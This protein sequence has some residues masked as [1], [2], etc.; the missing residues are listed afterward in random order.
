MPDKDRNLPLVSVLMTSYNGEK[1]IA[2]AIESVLASTYKDFELIIVDDCSMDRTLEIAE[3]YAKKDLRISVYANEK[4]LGDYPNRNRVAGLAKGKYLKYIDNDDMIYPYGLEVVVNMMEQFPDAGYG[5]MSFIQDDSRIYPYQ[6][7]AREAYKK[8]YFE[9]ALLHKAAS[10]SIIRTD[11]FRAVGGFT[12]KRMFGD[13][14]MWHILSRKYP[15][16]LL[17]DGVVWWRKHAEQEMQHYRYN[18]SIQFDYLL[19]ANQL[20]LHPESPLNSSERERAVH[21]IQKRQARYILRYFARGSFSLAINLLEKSNFS[22]LGLLIN[23]F[24]KA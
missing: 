19:V 21:F 20:L 10:S 11:I 1:Y 15:V 3:S 4:N 16:V 17:P 22:L 24:S 2:E 13:M 12:G 6:L 7:S 9:S 8:H 23:A 5:L 14:E 18:P